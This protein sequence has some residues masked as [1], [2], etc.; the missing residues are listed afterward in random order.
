MELKKVLAGWNKV[1][2]GCNIARKYPDSLIGRKVRAH[3]EKGCAAH[4]AYV[5][6]YGVNE[7][8][9]KKKG[10][11]K[12]AASPKNK[13]AATQKSS[14]AGPGKTKPAPKKA[15]QKGKRKR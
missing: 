5:E 3:W 8:N 4:D 15:H 12:A 11:A 6:V 13:A 9:S 2:P 14:V 1:C 10:A 7:P